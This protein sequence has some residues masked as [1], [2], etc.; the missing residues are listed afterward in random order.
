[1]RWIALSALASFAAAAGA[2]PADEPNPALNEPDR[3]AWSLFARLNQRAAVQVEVGP[4]K[5]AT[6]DSVWETWADDAQTFPAAP[7]RKAPPAWP[8]ARH[9]VLLRPR[10]RDLRRELQ[11]LRLLAAPGGAGAAQPIPVAGPGDSEEVRRNRPSFDYIVD[12]GLYYVQGLRAA[13]AKGT[14]LAFPLDAIEVK[15]NW[16]PI[17][18]G[19]KARYHWNYDSQGKLYGMV[20]MHVM[21]KL[22]PNWTWAT[23]EWVDNPGRCDFLG[24]HDAFGVLPHDVAPNATTDQGYPPGQ[25]TPELLALLDANGVA[26]EFRN[27][28]LKGSQVD[29][30]DATGRH[31]LLG[32][33]VTESGF[34]ASSSCLTCHT[35]S[36]ADLTGTI[37]PRA[38]FDP[39]N[40]SYNGAPDPAWFY[41]TTTQPW[42]VN[43]LPLDFV[44]GFIAAQPAVD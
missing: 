21:T 43:E 4:A 17:G 1:M 5:A 18:E 40:Q 19:D 36:S 34:V 2:A 25:L 26:P 31:M 29:F 44:W 24:C 11:R 38:G 39:D 20:A 41:D 9:K 12:D 23:F 3:L 42:S 32:N 35:Q 8:E 16:V 7:S 15:A 27:Y 13:F 28:R 22:V 6:N 10:Q 37:R 30:T 33:S 14:P